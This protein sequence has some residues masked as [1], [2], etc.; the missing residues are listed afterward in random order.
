MKKRWYRHRDAE[1]AKGA[2]AARRF[3]LRIC[4]YLTKVSGRVF[5]AEMSKCCRD[6]EGHI[7]DSGRIVDVDGKLV[8][9]GDGSDMTIGMVFWGGHFGVRRY[10]RRAVSKARVSLLEDCIGIGELGLEHTLSDRLKDVS[11]LAVDLNCGSLDELE[12][13]MT[14]YGC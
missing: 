8:P 11:C 1:L 2:K 7:L 6:Y 4:A 5:S 10:G 9:S 12:V 14:A 3:V 13:K